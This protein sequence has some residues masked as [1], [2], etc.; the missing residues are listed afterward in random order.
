MVHRKWTVQ[1]GPKVTLT[2]PAASARGNL[3][4]LRCRTSAAI[5][6]TGP[7]STEPET[8]RH[9]DVTA[10]P[11]GSDIHLVAASTPDNT[12]GGS[13]PADCPTRIAGTRRQAHAPF[14]GFR[15]LRA[16]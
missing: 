16:R 3:P 13:S 11:T 15:V 5:A 10:I 8:R 12:T 1:L 14:M 6:S 2:R 4:F 9:T 7:S